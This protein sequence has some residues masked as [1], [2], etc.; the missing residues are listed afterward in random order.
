MITLNVD[1]ASR[2]NPGLAGIGIYICEN[3][4]VLLEEKEYLGEKTN[5]EA[6]YLSLIIGLQRALEFGRNVSV[7]SD[8]EL[9]VNQVKG[10]YKA[11][12]P[13]L[14]DLLIK[15]KEEII[16]FDYFE[17]KHTRRENNKEADNLANEA[18]DEFLSGERQEFILE[19][20]K[21]EKLF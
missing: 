20:L 17:I 8:S 3:N 21:Q 4:K 12:Q 18:I 19:Y 10:T 11:K 13:H 14:K 2:G 6:E 16:K 9:I 7:V 15:A 5:N 1:G